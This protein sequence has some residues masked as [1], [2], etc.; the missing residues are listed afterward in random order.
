MKITKRILL[1]ALIAFTPLVLAQESDTDTNSETDSEPADKPFAESAN[2]PAAGLSTENTP[3][4]K[5][6]SSAPEELKTI[7]PTKL[8]F[9]SIGQM[10]TRSA[11][12]IG[13]S[14]WS[15]GGE[16]L[17]RDFAVYDNYKSYLGKLGAKGIRLQG[18]WAKCEK[19]PGVYSWE[20]LDKVVDDALSQGVQP[21]IQTSYGNPIYNGGGTTGL[22]GSLPS[23]PEALA[24]WDN[25]VRALV[26]RYKD[27]VKEWEIWNE[28]DLN[29]KHPTIGSPVTAEDYAKLFIR[30]AEIIRQEQPGAKIY[31]L[32]LA[33][34]ETFATEFLI[35][36]KV[37]GKTDL[38]DAVTVHGYPAN[39][40][41]FTPNR[42]QKLLKTHAP[43]VAVRQGE[44]G[45]PSKSSKMGAM[46]DKPWTEVKQAKWNLRRMMQHNGRNIPFNLFTLVDLK[47]AQSDMKG[48]NRKG[49]LFANDDMTVAR[50]KLSYLAAQNVFSIFDDSFQPAKI[51]KGPAPEI[52]L[53]SYQKKDSNQAVVTAWINSAPASESVETTPKDITVPGVVFTDPVYVDLISGK[54]YRI[55]KDQWSSDKKNTT[56]T[57]LPLWD[58][59]I[60][61]AEASLIPLK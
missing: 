39:P 60:A 7:D 26:Q 9:T 45:A 47:Y 2:K 16:T 28:P 17:D 49:L 57:K 15:I 31:G 33:G 22:G 50:P 59:P 11:S 21:W 43:K 44:T 52:S 58:C 37:L 35:W 8:G 34:E 36:L 14:M 30:T 27:R 6:V 46:S 32:A 13:S 53:F 42:M 10:K 40:D 24:A 5:Q 18:G 3:E 19:Q 1:A 4:S 23:S 12:E 41:E 20:W 38:L 56:F 54:V 55:P 29:A 61:I 25:W 51:L 48:M